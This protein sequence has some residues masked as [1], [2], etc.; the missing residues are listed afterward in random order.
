MFGIASRYVKVKIKAPLLILHTNTTISLT[1]KCT[2]SCAI[3]P[4]NVE[5][6]RLP[7]NFDIAKDA[8]PTRYDELGATSLPNELKNN[9]L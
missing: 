8:T 7:F 6:W 4:F 3:S 9:V 1:Q 2:I 5:V